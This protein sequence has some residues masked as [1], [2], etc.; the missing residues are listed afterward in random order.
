MILDLLSIIVKS[1]IVV[2]FSLLNLEFWLC[3]RL[4]TCDCYMRKMIA[5]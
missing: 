1:T 5:T 2:W 4:S 3:D